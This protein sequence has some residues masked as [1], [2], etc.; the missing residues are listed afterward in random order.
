MLGMLWKN[1]VLAPSGNGQESPYPK[2]INI[3]LTK[4]DNYDRSSNSSVRS[5][6]NDSTQSKRRVKK[7]TSKVSLYKLIS[8]NLD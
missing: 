7:R 3:L 4:Y 6:S 1:E 2:S 5:K 8:C